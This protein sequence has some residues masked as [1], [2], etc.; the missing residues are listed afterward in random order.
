[1]I[2]VQFRYKASR[3]ESF[4][5]LSVNGRII[6]KINV[7]ETEYVDEDWFQLARDRVQL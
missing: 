6:L 7:R 5:D 2:N 4:I 1:V 3:E